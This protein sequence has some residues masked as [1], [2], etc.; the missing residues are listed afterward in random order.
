MTHL[1]TS[2]SPNLI[3][4]QNRCGLRIILFLREAT[5]LCGIKKKNS[6]NL[7]QLIKQSNSDSACYKMGS[8]SRKAAFLDSY[9]EKT[10]PS[11][12]GYSYF[13]LKINLNLLN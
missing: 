1:E 3:K 13:L 8:Q 11:R 6:R 7:K 9:N 2:I 12:G 5:Q 4:T 10:L